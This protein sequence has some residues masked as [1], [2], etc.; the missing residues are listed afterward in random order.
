MFC[1]LD[2]IKQSEF[3]RDSLKI[4]RAHEGAK[5]LLG[6]PIKDY[7]D[8][9]HPNHADDNK[10]Y[11]EVKVKGTKENG[12]MFFWANKSDEKWKIEQ[13]ELQLDNDNKRLV[14]VKRTAD[15][16]TAMQ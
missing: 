8:I 16:E 4:L 1:F 12:T 10:A 9:M 3:Y 11:F 14:V 7:V 6:E 13:L 5:H 15:N 2:R